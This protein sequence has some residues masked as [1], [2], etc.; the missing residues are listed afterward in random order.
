MFRQGWKKELLKGKEL[1]DAA[2]QFPPL[3]KKEAP[4]NASFYFKI[5]YEAK[6]EAKSSVRM[7]MFNLFSNIQK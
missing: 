1:I 7:C 6:R 5:M 4:R 2:V 3:S